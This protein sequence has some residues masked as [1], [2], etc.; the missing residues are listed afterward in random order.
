MIGR[1]LLQCVFGCLREYPS[2]FPSLVENVGALPLLSPEKT[3]EN[4]PPERQFEVGEIPCRGN[5][6]S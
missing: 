1:L 3:T 4:P 6:L 2:I 5:S